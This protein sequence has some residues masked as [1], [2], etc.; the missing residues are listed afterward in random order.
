LLCV[1][2]Y[3]MQFKFV[4]GMIL[5]A[6]IFFLIFFAF[7]YVT[8]IIAIFQSAVINIHNLSLAPFKIIITIF[9]RVKYDNIVFVVIM[10]IS[11]LLYNLAIAVTAVAVAVYA[12]LVCCF[13]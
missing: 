5:S 12:Y 11:G 1:Y 7:V 13:I 4:S 2:W 3:F 10:I 6:V 9:I 8:L